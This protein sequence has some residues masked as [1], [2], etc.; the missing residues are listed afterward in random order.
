[1]ICEG[2]GALAFQHALRHDWQAT[3][4]FRLRIAEAAEGTDNRLIPMING[5]GLAEAYLEL[6]QLEQAMEDLEPALQMARESDS[7]IPEA[8]ALRVRARIHAAQGEWDPAVADFSRAAELC[9][10]WKSR[11]LLAQVLLD[12]G[13]LQADHEGQEPARATLQRALEIFAECGAEYWVG[14]AQTALQQL[15]AEGQGAES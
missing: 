4:D 7:P 9:E 2:L 14:R 12:W 5:P 13:L 3:L 10:Q 8:R 15:A 11:L 1:M 6:G